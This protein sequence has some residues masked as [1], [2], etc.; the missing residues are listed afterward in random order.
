MTLRYFLNIPTLQMPDSPIPKDLTILPMTSDD[1]EDVLNIERLSF[2]APWSRSQ[3]EKEIQN[4]FSGKFIAKIIHKGEEVVAAYIIFW[5][6][7]DEAHIL[8]IATHPDFRRRGIAR[9]LLS[10]TLSRLKEK[11]VREI[12]LEVRRS[13]APAQKLYHDFGFK[14]IGIR[15]GYYGNNNEDAIIMA[16]E[17]KGQHRINL[18][19]KDDG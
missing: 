8:N 11:G 9:A 4:P 10:F 17:V 1:L 15:E 13:N 16:L 18:K 14:K 2:P 7:A 3:F 5:V 12:F 19:R 6:V